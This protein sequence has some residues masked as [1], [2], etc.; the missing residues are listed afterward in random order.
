[1]WG[2]GVNVIRNAACVFALAASCTPLDSL[3]RS[4][5]PDLVV[6]PVT[7][8]H[9]T[10]LPQNRVSWA[11]PGNDAGEVAD[12]LLLSNLTLVLKRSPDRQLAFEQFL[13][14]Q[15]D[16]YSP[17]FHRWLTPAEVGEMFGA[18]AH[19]IDAVTAW[20]QAQGLRVDAVANSRVRIDFSGSAAQV[21]AAFGSR[22]HAY[23]VNGD[24]RIATAGVPQ[25]PAALAPIVQ[26]VHGLATIKERPQ[27]RAAAAQLLTPR[28][29]SGSPE[30]TFCSG[31]ACSQFI[32]PADFATIYDVN[33][34]YQQGIDGTGQTIAIITR[35]RVYLPDI[36]NFQSRSGLAI[37]DPVVIIPPG[38]V[39]PGPA[40]SS[41]GIP[42]SHQIEATVDVTRATSVAPGATIALITSDDSASVSGL[43]VTSQYVVDT[44]P[45]PAR[46]MNLSFGNCEANA[47]PA[48][49]A[50]WDSVF[51]QAAAEG[52]SVF[53]SSGDSGV[54]GCDDPASPPPASQLVSP[55]YICASSYATCV[56]G[57][58]F[59][60]A[61]NPSAYWSS[62]N[63]AG[64]ESALGYIPEGGWN[65]PLDSNGNPQVAASGGGVSTFVPT[66]SWQTVP[67]V[68][69]TQGRYTPD[70]SFTASI[71]DG[72]F[73]CLAAAGATCVS[74]GPFAVFGGTSA[75]APT[76]AG[77]AA[78]LNQKMGS[79][80]GNLNPGLYALAATPGNGVFHDVTVSTSNVTGCSAATPS[81]CNN[82]TPGPGGLG[83]GL[84]GYV[85]G[86]GYDLAT[87]LGSI[88]VANLL[89]Q[90]MG[91]PAPPP[92]PPPPPPPAPPGT[93]LAV[94]YYYAA[95]N[96]YFETAFP[97]EIAGLD[98]GAFGGVWKRTGQTF[99][100]WPTA[101]NP[102][103]VPTCRFFT[104]SFFAP[105]S[106]HFYTPNAVECNGL[107]ATS[108][109]WQFESIAFY[110]ALVDA[111]GFCPAG[112]MPLYRAYNSGM[113]GAPNHRYM[114]SLAIL[115][116]M[117]AAGWVFEGDFLTKVFACVPVSISAAEGE[118]DATTSGGDMIIGIVL[119]DGTFYF[120]Y[121]TSA[122][123]GMVQGTATY[124]NGQF[125]SSDAVDINFTGLGVHHGAFSGSYVPRASLNGVIS[126][127]AQTPNFTASYDPIYEQPANLSVVAGNYSGDVATAGGAATAT[128]TLSPSGAFSGTA[129]GCSFAGTLVPR[130]NVN[131]FNFA[132]T[133]QGACGA[134]TVVGI[135]L[136]DAQSGQL[137]AIGPNAARTDGFLAIGTRQ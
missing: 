23:L 44:Q 93:T 127:A 71:H 14:E 114:T 48:G 36:E 130:G 98:A 128:F 46:I 106:S 81:M 133:L 21:G 53:V 73:A 45:L 102:F 24:Q 76:M 32:F 129:S 80:Q 132:V 103:A 4:A 15:Q 100:V 12:D 26:A 116:Q 49:V 79:P 108:P 125:N 120:V 47:G 110:I 118:W 60:D 117:I 97:D 57:T 2:G 59:A 1:M 7:A 74:G 109:V 96:Y 135:A 94:E 75:T 84:S 78:L 72:Y 67:G 113:G 56:G 39:D 90:W 101:N 111:N 126:E 55:N 9:L 13:Q 69:G 28:A 34:V 70:V 64:F 62:T 54:A 121:T 25:L 29:P 8:A 35:G 137:L 112:T 31:G 66:P 11:T 85:V 33:P 5:G 58:E 131:V 124:S 122:S 18:S 86:P 43:S 42:P 77:I 10:A 37:K 3:A 123:V 20:L 89:A 22:M 88:D 61:A 50:F 115:N 99:F 107:I 92:P 51:S 119:D 68:P 19:D 40:Q 52:I 83:G 16:P 136:Y 65:E 87:G 82:S 17:N 30:A 104:G 95:W 105:K 134:G 63:G 41:G 27:Y 6:K 91:G 38:G